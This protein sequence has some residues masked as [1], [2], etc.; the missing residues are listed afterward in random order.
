MNLDKQVRR[1]LW[2]VLLISTVIRAFT[3][4]LLEFGN[5]EVYY[6]TYAMF[7]DWS[8]FDH[9]PMVGW[10]IQLF[11]LNL[12]FESE[13]FIRLAAVVSG[14]LST[15]M[16]FLIGKQLK[17]SL[18]GLYAALLFSSSFYCAVISGTFI[19]PDSPQVLFWLITLYFYLHALPD[20]TLSKESRRFIVIAGITTGL[21][22]LSKYHSVFLTAGALLYILLFNRKWLRTKE[23]YLS[24][25][26]MAVFFIPVIVWNFQNSFIS[27]SFH[28][29]RI[30]YVKP[31]IHWD[32]FLTE[33]AGEFF[34]NNPVNIVVILLALI[35]LIRG[36][37]FMDKEPLRIVLFFSVPLLLLFQG[38]S[39][40]RSILPHW[41]GPAYLGLILIAAAYLDSF[42][43]SGKK[44]KMFPLPVFLAV[45]LLF[46]ILILGVGQIR[47]GWIDLKKR[48]LD[49]FSGQL[50]GWKQLGEKTNKVFQN[51]LRND[52][53]EK[54]APLLTFRW[55][56]AANF[57]YYIC[58]NDQRRVYALGSLERVHKYYWINHENGSLKKGS[59]A[60][61]IVTSD[62]YNKPENFFGQL[63]DSIAPP[64]TLSINRGDQLIRE[65]Y[66]YRLYG[67]N[68]D[69]DFG[70]RDRY[71]GVDP[72]KIRYWEERI[73]L[74]PE[75]MEMLRKSAAERE[76]PMSD[77]IREAAEY[78]ANQEIV[79]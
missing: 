27:F 6:W 57:N 67:L 5:D 10:V 33:L 29:S 36:K 11:T 61:Y 58:R 46:L 4:G 62:D 55:F 31:G 34:Y 35:S 16:I 13:F 17:N 1:I 79:P 39:L 40:F 72:A 75:W 42:N 24:L 54:D 49:D 53:M 74:T 3:A 59:D 26:I 43:D 9:P 23:V 52:R 8:H 12:Y 78:M 28:E 70:V 56:P 37:K 66:I 50:Y 14:T 71:R 69:L 68:T 25:L 47:Y 64:D 30:D 20:K 51:D 38:I 45:S 22:M 41:T 15:W 44:N 7:P 63:F 2:V 21:A 77:Q 18:T 60:Y 76:I 65:A 32:Y 73:R 19:M 48:G